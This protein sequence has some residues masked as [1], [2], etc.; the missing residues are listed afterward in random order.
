MHVVV[1]YLADTLNGGGLHLLTQ[2]VI[3]V[4]MHAKAVVKTLMSTH[5]IA[6]FLRLRGQWKVLSEVT[7]AKIPEFKKLDT[8]ARKL[9]NLLLNN[10][11]K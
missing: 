11:C 5:H 3:N 9:T 4:V 8:C 10:V 1:H 6:K 2:Q 7:L